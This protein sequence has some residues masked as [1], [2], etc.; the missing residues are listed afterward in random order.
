MDLLEHQGKR[1]FAGAGLPVLPSVCVT[2]AAEAAPAADDLGLPVVVKAQVKSGGRGKA[3]GIRVCATRQEVETAAAEILAMT[4]RGKRVEALLVEP[5]VEIAREMYL[6]VSSSRALRGPVLV[7]SRHGGVEIEQTAKDDPSALVR[8]SLD[9]L[10][11]LCDYQVRDVVMAARLDPK[12]STPGG[13]PLPTALGAVVR[14]LWRLYS[15][16]DAT[17]CEVNPLVLTAT[18][19]LLCLDSKVTIDDS[20]LYRHPEIERQ[21]SDDAREAAAKAAGLAFVSLDGDLGVIGNG[22]GL[23]MSTLDQIAAEGGSAANFCDLGGGARSEVVKAALDV[24]LSSPRVGALLVS[25]FGGITRC[26]EVARGL[27]E[28]FAATEI[29]VPVVVRLDGN[30]AAEGQA[31]L[32]QAAL[33]GV[34]IAADAGNAVRRAVAAARGRSGA[35]AGEEG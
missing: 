12:A 26:D 8:R 2:T 14:A 30:A 1:L 23:V 19:E 6:A 15:Q 10:L 32:A 11:G 25:I 33:P 3:G 16:A 4:I 21:E 29:R 35:R 31:I 13:E 17:L 27:V 5:A 24:V 20:A 28:A 34:E 7:F 9:P 18:G 22:A